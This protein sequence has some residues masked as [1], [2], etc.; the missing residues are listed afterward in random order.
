VR[1]R[2]EFTEQR[3]RRLIDQRFLDRVN[4]SQGID[5]HITPETSGTSTV[6]PSL[7]SSRNRILVKGIY[8]HQSYHNRES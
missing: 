3:S 8:M 2:Y 6:L 1:I 7:P 4:S 5:S